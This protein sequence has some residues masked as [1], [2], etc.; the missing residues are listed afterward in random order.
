MANKLILNFL[1]RLFRFHIAEFGYIL[2]HKVIR[3]PVG[4]S[5]DLLAVIQREG[6]V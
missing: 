6:A 1:L 2:L 3:I 4:G 5:P